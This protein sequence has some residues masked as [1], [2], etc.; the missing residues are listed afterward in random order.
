MVRKKSEELEKA[1]LNHGLQRRT[2]DQA[3]ATVLQEFGDSIRS[4]FNTP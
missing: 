3:L 1:P 4:A 2:G